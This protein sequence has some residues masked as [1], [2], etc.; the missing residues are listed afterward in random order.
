MSKTNV[1]KTAE[2]LYA[3]SAGLAE[4]V[5]GDRLALQSQLN[6]LRDLET[7]IRAHIRE[8]QIRQRA[9]AEA[10][11]AAKAVEEALQVAA[12]QERETGKPIETAAI[13]DT[14]IHAEPEQSAVQYT[15]S[16]AQRKPQQAVE[17]ASAHE[18]EAK[19]VPSEPKEPPQ[20]VVRDDA[21]PP[22]REQ[23]P[24]AADPKRRPG[25]PPAARTP[26]PPRRE[27]AP[28]ASNTPGAYSTDGGRRPAYP[29]RTAGGQTPRREG[30]APRTPGQTPRYPRTGVP[31]GRSAR[32]GGPGMRSADPLNPKKLAKELAPVQEKEKASNYNPNKKAYT[33]DKD[34]TSARAR[35]NKKQLMR[36]QAPLFNE[37]E[38]RFR[39]KRRRQQHIRGIEKKVIDHAVITTE[40]VAIKVLAERIGVPGAEIIK[41]LLLLGTIANIN[42]EIDFDT[43][44]L[45]ASEFN[46]TLEQKL[47]K[48]FEEVMMDS[49]VGND[50]GGLV[51]RP[52][53]VTIMGH[54][55]HGK[56]SLLDVIR[57]SHV[58]ESEAGGIT[59]HIGAYMID[60]NG[61]AITF[62]D[63]PGHEAFTAMRSRGAQVTDI[64][65]LVVAAND[66]VKPQTVE[67]INHAKAAKVPIIVAINKIDL[68]AADADRV[69]RELMEHGLVPEEWGGE[70]MMVEVSAQTR[71]G[72]DKLLESI[73]LLAEIEDLTANPDARAVGTVI[74]AKLDRGRGP[75]A[76][77]LV[78]NGTLSIGDT[79][80]AGTTSGRIRDMLDESGNHVE[81]ATPSM[82]VEIVGFSQVPE[83]GDILH[84]AEGDKLARR[85]AQER[86]EKI[87]IERMKAAS[88]VTLDDLFTK[89]SEDE[90]KTLNIIIRGDVQGSVEAVKQALEK[91]TTDEVKIQSIHDGVGAITENDVMLASASDAIII[92]FNVRPDAN[93]REAADREKVDVRLYR[94]IY[95]AIE[96]M[97]KAIKGMLAPEVRETVLGHAQV[98]DIFKI[99]GVGAIAGGYVTDG[100]IRRNAKVRVLRD[101][102]IVHEGVLSSLKRFK[103]DVREV[104][105]GYECGIGV[106]GFNDIKQDDVIEAFIM[107]EIQR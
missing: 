21:K 83:A 85:V 60:V 50:E 15:E 107:E 100:I 40:T 17:A 4:K 8:E 88:K 23:S 63:T 91:L 79:I 86:Q 34:V 84:S 11:A 30:F 90:M 36:E 59:Q 72:I 97:E 69:R 32:T 44:S 54:V 71:T 67:A 47:D 94:I 13:P 74:E 19:P 104:A 66:G 75:V 51:E 27:G 58:T 35:K 41:K 89:I 52:P 39:K 64:A 25:G 65:V 6:M 101:S 80:V 20:A 62:L 56:T 9:A 57:K 53:V 33:R 68:P 102:V 5:R 105:S 29:P 87:K 2:D 14:P 16:D 42:Q 46:V 31:E 77:V 22:R 28:R 1:H 37:D 103:D 78:N 73:L 92:G 95:N 7:R 45:I 18:A 76:T 10:E 43:A 70:N 3:A 38:M 82:P 81:E 61:K 12:A 26:V 106:S 96:D 49:F 55:D 93:A 98:R 24:R 99:P 48:T